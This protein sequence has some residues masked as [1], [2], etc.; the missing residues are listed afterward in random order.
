MADKRWIST[1]GNASSTAS[2]SPSGVPVDF[3]SIY[4]DGSS[5]VDWVSNLNV[6]SVSLIT[7]T[8]LWFQAAYLGNAG[9]VGN[10][11]RASAKHLIHNGSGSVYHFAFSAAVNP[12]VVIDSPNQQDAYTLVDTDGAGGVNLTLAFLRGGSRIVDNSA[13]VVGTILVDNATAGIGPNVDIGLINNCL[14][15]RQNGGYVVTKSKLGTDYAGT[16]GRANLDGGTLVYHKEG[17]GAW[18]IVEITGGRMEYNG[19]GSM[20]NCIVSGGILDM[21]KD[22][23][24]KTITKLT[25][26]RGATFL[27]HQN[28]TVTTLIDLRPTYPILP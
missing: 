13:I 23:R 16:P 5:N 21:T 8:R 14:V 6:F 22:S 28:I 1:D 10:P 4:C 19:T 7:Q 27:T 17:T 11:L 2:Y 12:Y 26:M 20:T 24:A 25:L 15:Y 3:D 9:A 18:N